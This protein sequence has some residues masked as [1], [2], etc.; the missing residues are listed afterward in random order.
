ME[1]LLGIIKITGTDT[2]GGIYGPMNN[3]VRLTDPINIILRP[4]NPS[5]RVILVFIDRLL[6]L[7]TAHPHTSRA[8]SF[9]STTAGWP[10][11]NQQTLSIII[12]LGN[13]GRFQ[14][15]HQY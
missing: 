9:V 4:L 13:L 12:K 6:L 7:L 8:T 3:E 11:I 5:H 2:N 10:T 15:Y 14:F 1:P